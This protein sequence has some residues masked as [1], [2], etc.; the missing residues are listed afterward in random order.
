MFGVLEDDVDRFL[1]HAA[2]F[3]VIVSLLLLF[4]QQSRHDS[5][6][7]VHQAQIVVKVMMMS[8]LFP[9]AAI[10]VLEQLDLRINAIQI[11]LNNVQWHKVVR[12]ECIQY[13]KI[14]Q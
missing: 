8:I 1:V 9:A 2:Q 5:A 12:R 10:F 6:Q 7:V 14:G 4:Q 13:F 11:F 3:F